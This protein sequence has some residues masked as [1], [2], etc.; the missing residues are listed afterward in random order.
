[1]TAEPDKNS[2]SLLVDSSSQS[3][4][5]AI[6]ADTVVKKSEL[7][8]RAPVS[9][10]PV[11]KGRFFALRQ[12][13]PYWQSLLFGAL[14][15]AMIAAVW[16][17]VTRGETAEV[18]M[19]SPVV[20]PSP[21]ETFGE[22]ESLWFE[23]EL[24]RNTWAS[25]KRVLLGFSLAAVIGVPVGVLCG[26]FPWFNAF[27]APMT[28]FGRNIPIAALL[29][30]TFFFFGAAETQKVMFIFVATV[31]FVIIDT[32]TAV[33]DV[34]TRYIDTAYTL[35]AS[36]LQIIWKVLVPL[37]MP[38]VCNSLRLLFGLA[39]G[40]IMLAE[41]VKMGSESGGLGD[42]IINSQKR[43]LREPI[44]LI[45]IL[46]P[47]VALTIDRLFYW[48][49]RQLFPFQYGGDGILRA[50]L[51]AISHGLEDLRGLIFRPA[52]VDDVYKRLALESGTGAAVPAT[53]SST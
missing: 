37:A 49:Q 50:L 25:L 52:S 26:C 30:L 44:Y 28:L 9:R 11:R 24:T 10:A 46:I 19:V 14:F 45:L 31:A 8:S 32:A 4:E 5:P 6:P 38:S 47:I 15:L 23:R 42:I 51:R 29:P 1:M 20:L 43:G 7:V 22:L 36:R 12:E 13:I 3:V 53:S 48:I 17:G 2:K 18:R 40:Y 33:K 27:L 16:W 34:S 35:G 39:F 21:E 41:A